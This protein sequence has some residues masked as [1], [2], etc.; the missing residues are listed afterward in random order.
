MRGI[1]FL[2]LHQVDLSCLIIHPRHSPADG[3]IDICG[4]TYQTS[5]LVH[6]EIITRNILIKM[7]CCC[8]VPWI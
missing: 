5:L 3:C 6:N 8:Q 2:L 7:N 4:V 1:T